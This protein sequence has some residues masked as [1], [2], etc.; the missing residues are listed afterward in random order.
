MSALTINYNSLNTIARNA[1]DLARKAE[2]YANNLT[3]TILE[4]LGRKEEAKVERAKALELGGMVSE[5]PANN[6]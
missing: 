5:L 1:S 2:E 3:S 6:Q 4:D